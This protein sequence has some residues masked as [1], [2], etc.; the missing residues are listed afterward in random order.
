MEKPRV[1][2]V[3]VEI[4]HTNIMRER[5]SCCSKC[6]QTACCAAAVADVV[7]AS[8]IYISITLNGL[9]HSSP[10]QTET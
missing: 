9:E 8:N 4:D 1:L 5:Y 6:V 7:L 3:R 10:N 2:V